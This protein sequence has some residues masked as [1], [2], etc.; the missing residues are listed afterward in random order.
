[1][2]FFVYLGTLMIPGV[3]TMIPNYIILNRLGWIDTYQG[4]IL[5]WIFTAY[6]TFLLRQFFMG[7]PRDLEDAARIDGCST[8]GCYW[9]IILPLSKP[10]LATLGVF[11][12]INVWRDFLWPL[13]VT[14]SENMRT[15]TV[16]LASFKGVYGT[17]WNLLMC[18]SLLVMLPM[19]VVFMFAQRYFTEGIRMTGLKG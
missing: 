5:P 17:E 15:L 14:D 8:F 13:I 6:G 12:F 18:G 1:M 4:L 11:T 19:I 7:I 9:R 10:A 2:L 3:V 16:G